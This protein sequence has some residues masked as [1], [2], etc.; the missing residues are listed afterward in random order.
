MTMSR[1]EETNIGKG[2][3]Q[4]SNTTPQ[5][6][7][8]SYRYRALHQHREKNKQKHR[9]N[10]C[11]HSTISP[12]HPPLQAA[13]EQENNEHTISKAVSDRTAVKNINDGGVAEGTRKKGDAKKRP[14]EWKG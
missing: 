1:L 13:P 7:R 3:T 2:D 9:Q 11:Q 6:Q 10:T 14:N 8:H 12:P 5:T 4:K